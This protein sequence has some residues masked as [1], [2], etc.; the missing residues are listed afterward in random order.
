MKRRN[1]NLNTMA[2]RKAVIKATRPLLLLIIIIPLLCFM[3]YPMINMSPSN[4]HVGIVNLDEGAK[5][6]QGNVNLGKKVLHNITDTKSTKKSAVVWEIYDSKAAAKKALGQN[7]IYGYLVIP[8]DFSAKQ[9]VQLTAFNKLSTA[10]G[11]MST[12]TGKLGTAVG[13]VGSSLG[14]LPA[15][16]RKVSTATGGLSKLAGGLQTA[17]GMV[18]DESGTIAASAASIGKDNMAIQG[19]VSNADATLQE[20]QNK[21]DNGETITADDLRALKSDID[22][23]KSVNSTANVL[24]IQKNAAVITAQAAALGKGL[25]TLQT[26]DT[27]MS[28]NFSTM[29][30]NFDK[31]G[32]GVS[33]ISTAMGS[34][35]TGMS[36]MSDSLSGKVGESI[37]TINKGS[38][39]GSNSKNTTKLTFV[40]DQSRNV[41]VVTTLSSAMNSLS[42]KSGMKVEIKYV[43]KIPSDLNNMY[44]AMAFMMMTMFASLITGAVTGL[45]MRS[46]GSRINRVKTITYQIIIALAIAV[47]VGSLEPRVVQ[48]MSG[49]SLPLGDISKYVMIASFC[50]LILIIGAIDL[51]GVAGVAIPVLI[52]FCGIAVAN[53]PYEYLPAFWQ[54]YVYSWEPLR[55]LA[56][57][58]RDILYRGGMF[59]NT[60]SQELLILVAVG[61]AC[62]V[63]SL[64]KKGKNIDKGSEQNGSGS[65]LKEMPENAVLE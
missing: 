54:K 9:T 61:A 57:G 43:N 22:N 24:M 16:F 36:K 21:L 33:T 6:T 19:Y 39:T 42:A 28:Q 60:Y 5:F 7:D 48:W 18:A 8:K 12:G 46:V 20:L 45:T 1:D 47:C 31:A 13:T 56:D 25:G 4:L 59:W 2:R 49:A 15:A 50:L 32:T 17:S 53:L 40:V 41:F 34:L 52:M 51:L 14:D 38:T 58:I 23:A 44:F 62:M 35:S 65:E 37:D 10:L 27:K 63:L 29:A 3:F 30:A 11:T 64:L 55:L 26:A